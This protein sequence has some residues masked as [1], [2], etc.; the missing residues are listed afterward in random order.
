MEKALDI[1]R[2][3]DTLDADA[4]RQAG[5]TTILCRATYGTGKDARWDRFAPEVKAAGL[6][7]GAYGFATWHYRSVNGGSVD[8]ARTAMLAQT[9]ALIALALAAGA[10][11][12]VAVDQELEAGQS[13]G[14]DL[15]ANTALLAES[16]ERIRAAGLHPC[17]YCSAGWADARINTAVLW[18]PLWIAWYYSDPADPDFGGCTPLESLP[19]KWGDYLR[20]LGQQ[21]CAWQ[22]G[23]IGF[24]GKYGVGSANVDRDWICYQ[25]EKEDI[26]ME[27][28]PITGKQLRCTSAENPKCETFNSADIND[29]LGVLELEKTYTITA[30]GGT[31]QLAG[32]T[33]TWYKIIVAGAEVFCL[34][35]PDGR[36]VVED[37][38]I[39]EPPA[40]DLTEVLA[41]LGRIETAQSRI[42][43]NQAAQGKQLAALQDKLIAAGAALAK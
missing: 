4:A 24:G 3:Q 34:E 29:S 41:A 32:M 31:I 14:L 26:P 15:D 37:A 39:V 27:F 9:D 21:L 16:C 28:E 35:L 20:G 8:T 43:T 6:R 10:D 33:G 13:M 25:P 23:R 1:S 12:W 38:P 36:C 40:V 19:G 5:I 17:V 30:R 7:L 18:A 42:E 11:S 22:F 2:W